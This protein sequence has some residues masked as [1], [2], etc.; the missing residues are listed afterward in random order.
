[1]SAKSRGLS[2]ADIEGKPAGFAMPNVLVQLV[3]EH[4]RM[5]TYWP[6]NEE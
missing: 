4:D 6:S 1:M 5:F 3:V 2:A